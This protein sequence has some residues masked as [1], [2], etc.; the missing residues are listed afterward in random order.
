MATT[1]S[2]DIE[3]LDVILRGELAAVE[4]YDQV[5]E[6]FAGKLTSSDLIKVR[7]EHKQH[8]TLLNEQLVKFGATPSTT[9]G[10]WGTFTGAVT[11]V[12]K[13]I[14]PETALAALK[15]GEE[16]G[17]AQY[18]KAI[19]RKDLSAETIALLRTEL[20]PQSHAHVASLDRLISAHAAAS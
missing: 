16:H 12:A 13:L 15:Q 18:E 11:S 5:L 19:E 4:T 3:Y 2:P 14:G 1:G 17:I 8:I 6:K 9:S 20:L 7:D 10:T